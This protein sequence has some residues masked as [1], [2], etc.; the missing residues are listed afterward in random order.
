[1]SVNHGLGLLP[2]Q[3]FTTPDTR[4]WLSK[5]RQQLLALNQLLSFALK[6]TLASPS[7]WQT[8]KSWATGQELRMTPDELNYMGPDENLSQTPRALDL[9]WETQQAQAMRHSI[10][11][12]GGV[13][14]TQDTLAGKHYQSGVALAISYKP[15]TDVI[16]RLQAWYE[17]AEVQTVAKVSEFDS[18]R[19]DAVVSEMLVPVVGQDPTDDILY[20]DPSALIPRESQQQDA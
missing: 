12:A 17:T 9:Q 7:V 13:P 11:R 6:E 15:Y 8:T 3:L 5:F 20:P 16:Q 18:R 19:P 1:M 14:D 10:L 2:A 4:P